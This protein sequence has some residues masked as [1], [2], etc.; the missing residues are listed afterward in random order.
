MLDNFSD[1]IFLANSMAYAENRRNGGL[2]T[3]ANMMDAI[4]RF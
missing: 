1:F 4:G 3:D 2:T